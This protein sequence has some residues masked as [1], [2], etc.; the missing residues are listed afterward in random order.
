MLRVL[1]AGTS[2]SRL[3][4]FT[5]DALRFRYQFSALL[6]LQQPEGGA[7]DVTLYDSHWEDLL[8]DCEL[9]GIS[10]TVGVHVQGYES[11][12]RRARARHFNLSLQ[13]GDLYIFNSNRLHVVPPVGIGRERIV[14]GSF[15]GY[16]S[17]ELRSFA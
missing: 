15:L 6:M 12:R 14:L 16:S 9:S 4:S 11:S 8:D 7:A 10:H 3:A 13:P 1:A 5:A 2:P 17:T